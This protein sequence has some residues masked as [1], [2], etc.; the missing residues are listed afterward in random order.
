MK[1]KKMISLKYSACMLVC[2]ALPL[3]AAEWE[4]SASVTPAITYTDNVCLSADNEQSEWI[5]LV[6]PAGTVEADGNRANLSVDG[7][8]EL[9]TL[10]DSKL[11]DRGCT[12]GS[13]GNREQFAP[14]LNGNADAIIVENWFYIDATAYINQNQVTPFASGG[15]DSLNRT[16]NTNTT[17]SYSVSPYLARRF[18]DAAEMNIRYTWDDQYNTTDAVRDS[19]Q[20]SWQ[21]LINSVP[22]ISSFSWG[23]QGDY[24]NVSYSN[25]PVET[26]N[27]QDSE[28]KSAQLNLGYQ[29]DRRWQVNGFYGREWND[30]V[31]NRDDI[32]GD[33]WDIGLR[34]TPNARTTVEAGVGDR[35][36]GNNPRFSV[37]HSHKRSA[38]SADY[39]K[40]LTY[41]RNIRT[42]SDSPPGNPDF[43]PPPGVDPGLTTITNS[44]ILDERYTLGYSYQGLRTGFGVSAFQSE[45]TKEGGSSQTGFTE[46]T[47]RGVTVSA[48]RSLSQQT[49][50]NASVNWN[51]QEPKTSAGEVGSNVF[52]NSETWAGLLGISR[53][54]T[55]R[56]NLGLSY[57]YTDRQSD[58]DI[59]SYTENRITLNF[60][61]DL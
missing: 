13:F 34:W 1:Y 53:Q 2:V 29:L 51:E 30:F 23:V 24:S 12:G 11:E 35:F 20:E 18:K 33:Y 17:Y 14:R 59:N 46:S 15:G 56:S 26:D 52:D 58:N 57:R 22:G 37:T 3:S 60:R 47:Y 44:P 45:Q 25:S 49:S 10:S 43:P 39:A 21:A 32:D 6:T 50:L 16:G 55:Q 31:S 28:L 42:L 5:G 54:L 9:N 19:S 27:N 61:V 4:T 48:N 7:A 8:V 38:F 36:Y 40:N 41:D